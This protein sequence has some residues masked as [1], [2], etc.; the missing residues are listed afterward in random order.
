[1]RN[2]IEDSKCLFCDGL[3]PLGCNVIQSDF[4]MKTVVA[5][6]Y[7]IIRILYDTHDI[8]GDACNIV[9]ASCEFCTV[10]LKI[11]RDI[12]ALTMSCKAICMNFLIA[13]HCR[14]ILNTLKNLLKSLNGQNICEN[15]PNFIRRHRN[16]LVIF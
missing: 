12:T 10:I 1:M 2:S 7:L 9:L 13:P 16:L 4:M 11:L 6:K 8:I 5:T 3:V 14:M 15:C